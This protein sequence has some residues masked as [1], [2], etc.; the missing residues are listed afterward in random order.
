MSKKWMCTVALQRALFAAGIVVGFVTSSAAASP[1]VQDPE[2]RIEAKYRQLGGPAGMLGAPIDEERR[3]FEDR[4]RYRAYENGFIY[5]HP[6]AGAHVISGAIRTRWGAL[7]REMGPLGYPM[8]DVMDLPGGAGQWSRFER[9]SI[10]WR[11]SS[12]QVT[13]RVE[14]RKPESPPAREPLAEAG[15]GSPR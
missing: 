1:P 8:T 6:A 4:G 7:G 9:G 5:W 14:D 13:V 10:E 15:Q 11:P 12:G 3:T 2:A